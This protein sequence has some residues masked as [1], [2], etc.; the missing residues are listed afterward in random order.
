[1]RMQKCSSARS[2]VA[3]NAFNFTPAKQFSLALVVSW[4]VVIQSVSVVRC[5]LS[6]TRECHFWC[7]KCQLF[8]FVMR[9]SALINKNIIFV[10]L[11]AWYCQI[12]GLWGQF[13]VASRCF[14]NTIHVKKHREFPFEYWRTKKI[15]CILDWEVPATSLAKE[16]HDKPQSV[17]LHRTSICVW[18]L[19]GFASIS[20]W[21]ACISGMHH[22][23]KRRY[24]CYSSASTRLKII[25]NND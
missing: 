25:M 8:P 15:C 5:F 20:L 19:P 22:A 9:Q 11:A 4:I 6:S 12:Y 24:Y 10:V 18:S 3:G 23:W 14:W 17:I 2:G 16:V 13:T 1:M 7:R 21:S